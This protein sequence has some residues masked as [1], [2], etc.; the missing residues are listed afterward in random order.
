MSVIQY[1]SVA[2]ALLLTLAVPG[3][4]YALEAAP[5]AAEKDLRLEVLHGTIQPGSILKLSLT[6]PPG[7][8][9]AMSFQGSSRFFTG[10][11]GDDPLV[12]FFGLGWDARPG[13]YHVG[14]DVAMPD[15]SM[16]RLSFTL[17]IAERNFP[18]QSITVKDIFITAPPESVQRIA[19]ETVLLHR[20]FNASSAELY[21][22][23]SFILPLSGK[24]SN[25]FGE[26]RIFNGT[27][28]SRH[29]GIDIACP[30]G[31]PVRA[32]NDGRIV[33]ARDLYYSGKTVIIDHGLGLFTFYCHFSQLNAAEGQFVSSGEI[34]GL[35][36]ATGRVTGPHLHW[37][38]FL[39][40]LPVDP[41]SLLEMR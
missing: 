16:K 40:N 3:A 33:I 11:G 31:T 6:G 22:K 18:R 13:I 21:G 17:P 36:G 20:I 14:I 38:A 39:G 19:D 10:R 34:I 4:S 25:N 26:W 35:A 37:G 41:L 2:A 28:N 12:L 24:V 30:V 7:T 9:A 27:K 1:L 15:G 29:R 8:N 5:A 23:R 32:S